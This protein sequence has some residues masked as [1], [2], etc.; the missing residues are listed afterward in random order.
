MNT[1]YNF[2]T[3]G[4]LSV[5]ILLFVFASSCSQDIA[6]TADNSIQ[7]AAV[8][9]TANAEGGDP[10]EPGTFSE[11]GFTPCDP[12]PSGR[13]QP[14]EGQISCIFAE[15]GRFVGITGAVSATPC[16]VGTFSD[17]FGASECTVCEAR[18]TTEGPGATFCVV[19]TAP[20]SKDDCKKGGWKNFDFKNQGQCIR[21]VET[22]K[23]SR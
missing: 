21:F 12:C 18:E 20:T 3:A 14:E 22:G 13:Y 15:P 7:S 17:I 8:T 16:P 23:D 4:Y 5:L 9:S 19:K 11:D 2:S 10:C 1:Q 6:G